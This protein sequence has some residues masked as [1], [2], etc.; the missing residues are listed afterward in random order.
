[1]AGVR[2]RW[3]LEGFTAGAWLGKEVFA[4]FRAHFYAGGASSERADRWLS[5]RLKKM[6]LNTVVKRPESDMMN[7]CVDVPIIRD[8]VDPVKKPLVLQ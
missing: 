8:L 4:F 6:T 7:V 2:R 3:R 5:D 1:M